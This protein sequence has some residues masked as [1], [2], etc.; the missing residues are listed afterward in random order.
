M[1]RILPRR[2]LDGRVLLAL[3]LS[4]G[5]ALAPALAEA[6]AGMS[7]GGRASSFG[8]RGGRT[9]QPNQA[10]P[11]SRSATPQP[12][13]GIGASPFGSW[14]GGSFFTRHPFLTG[15]AG[16][17]I[18]SWLFGHA[19]YA[20]TGMGGH[21]LLGILFEL[22]IIG[23]LIYFALRL[24]RG[25]VP[26]SAGTGMMP[27]AFAG[28]GGAMRLARGH[29][30]NLSDAELNAFQRLHAEIQDAWSAGDLGRL[31]RSV[32]PEMLG[33]F[34]EELS[35][36]ASQ[37]VRNIVTDVELLQGELNEAWEEDDLQYATAFMRWRALD[38]TVQLG[39]AP[40][41]AGVVVGGDPRRPI[42]AEEVWTFMRRR[43][44]HWLLSAIQQV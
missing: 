6:R 4:I 31:Q 12:T 21:S 28:A 22:A 29:D 15:L 32:T 25:W 34:S 16:G 33:Y 36:N 38:Y 17:F 43:G 10:Q 5:L 9:W 24:I 7:F 20:G 42:E 44:G 13:P 30:I 39:P 41:G 8:S 35:R 37:G 26:F 19:G 40:G 11:L 27:N 23:G 18:G 1:V 2:P 3:F 14:G